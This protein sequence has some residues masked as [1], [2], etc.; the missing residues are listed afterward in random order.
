VSLAYFVINGYFARNKE[1]GALAPSNAGRIN[2]VAI[3]PFTNTSGNPEMEYLSDGI[4]ESL[5]NNLSQVPGLRVIARSS[6]FKYK[7]K[8]SDLQEVAN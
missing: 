8:E 5:I 6:S 7:G 1:A 2:S 4:S 3:L